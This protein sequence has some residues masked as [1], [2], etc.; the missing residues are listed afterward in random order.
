M[1]FTL[2]LARLMITGYLVLA[3]TS[4]IPKHALGQLTPPAEQTPVKF[5]M[6]AGQAEEILGVKAHPHTLVNPPTAVMIISTPVSDFHFSRGGLEKICYKGPAEGTISISPFTTHHYN[7]PAPPQ[8][9]LWSGMKLDQFVILLGEWKRQLESTGYTE[10]DVSRNVGTGKYSVKFHDRRPSRLWYQVD[11]GQSVQ[12]NTMSSPDGALW[13]FDFTDNGILRKIC[14]T[15]LTRSASYV[16]LR[17][18]VEL[19]VEGGL[20]IEPG[21]IVQL[22]PGE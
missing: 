3:A 15:D 2:A 5:G 21:I 13:F 19:A 4:M 7:P 22:P 8:A 6:S 14:A 9:H 17:Q 10:S 1:K 20:K 11:I 18:A 12:T 16:E